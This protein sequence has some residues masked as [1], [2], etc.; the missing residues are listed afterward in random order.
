[1]NIELNFPPKFE[2]LVLVHYYSF[3]SLDTASSYRVCAQIPGRLPA[4]KE[5]LLFAGEERPSVRRR[6][7][8]KKGE[9]K[10]WSE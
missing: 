3:V 9:Q 6:P 7:N 2:G 4:Y 8:A 10:H 1:M 5:N